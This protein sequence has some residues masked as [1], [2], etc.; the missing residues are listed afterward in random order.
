ME[1]IRRRKLL[2]AAPAIGLCLIA[3][4]AGLVRSPTYT[5]ETRLQVGGVNVTTESIPGFVDSTVQ[6]AGNYSRYVSAEGVIGPIAKELK[7]PYAD[8]EGRVSSSPVP[9][10]NI[11]RVQATGGSGGEAEKLADTAG[12]SL[13]TFIGGLNASTSRADELYEAIK[14]AN[15]ELVEAQTDAAAA[16]RAYRANPG[17]A[18]LRAS[19][20]AQANVRSL[21]VK[22]DSAENAYRQATVGQG[23]A[24]TL[25]VVNPATVASNDRMATLQKLLFVALVAGLISGAALATARA[26]WSGRP[27]RR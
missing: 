7:L 20:N 14:T 16:Q 10:S 15:I 2:T 11:I 9:N 3:L 19:Q 17:D 13:I 22:V 6:L 18:T 21:A 24:G 8:V 26:N 27:R 5:A 23:S 12:Q 1:A 4:L 25:N